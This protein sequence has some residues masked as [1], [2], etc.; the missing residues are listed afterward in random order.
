MKEFRHISLAALLLLA[1]VSCRTSLP[2]DAERPLCTFGAAIGETTSRTTLTDG[3]KVAWS[4]GDALRIFSPSCP[5]GG[6]FVIDSTCAGS[7]YGSFTGFDIGAGPYYAVY[8]AEAALALN[9]SELSVKLPDTQVYA[10]GSF[11]DGTNISVSRSDSA[12]FMMRNLCGALRLQLTGSASITSVTLSSS[13]VLAGTARVTFD[14][15]GIPATDLSSAP[16]GVK[17]ITLNCPSAVRLDKNEA[18][19][20]HF[21][22]P[23]GTL[24][25]GFTMKATDDECGTWEKTAPAA[26]KNTVE[27]SCMKLMSVCPYIRTSSPF[28]IKSTYGVYDLSDPSDPVVVRAYVKKKDQY[29]TRKS[30]T[31]YQFRIQNLTSSQAVV[32]DVPLKA[33]VG[34]DYRIDVTSYGNTGVKSVKNRKVR[35]EGAN[36]ARRWYVDDEGKTGYIIPK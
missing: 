29:A 24:A 31:A 4:K 35:L 3:F 6:V 9:G 23:A 15:S 14:G 28:L 18:T 2:E 1:A 33:E 11:A 10:P 26:E 8:P 16:D 30:A 27:R 12:F 32:I 34:Q 21:I 25:G 20:F 22:V 19:A 5:E 13:D 36:A 17:A 7:Q